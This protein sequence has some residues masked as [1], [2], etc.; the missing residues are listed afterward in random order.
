MINDLSLLPLIESNVINP[1]LRVA[2]IDYCGKMNN[3]TSF[4]FKEFEMSDR[5]ISTSIQDLW[6]GKLDPKVHDAFEQHINGMR[7]NDK[8][9]DK[10]K[11]KE[12]KDE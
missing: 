6:A 8:I 4:L 5:P 3:G 2:S 12:Q 10:K 1:K 11:Q 7:L 9:T